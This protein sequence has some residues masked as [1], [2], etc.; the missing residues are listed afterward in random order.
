MPGC[1][2]SD[3]LDLL[4]LSYDMNVF[5]WYRTRKKKKSFLISNITDAQSPKALVVHLHEQGL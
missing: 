5:C 4:L 1:L 3:L 2:A